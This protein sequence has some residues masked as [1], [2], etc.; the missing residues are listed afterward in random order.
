MHNIIV[1]LVGGGSIC[2]ENK[3]GDWDFVM[4][5]IRHK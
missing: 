3:V 2:G 1:E 4:Q 5:Y